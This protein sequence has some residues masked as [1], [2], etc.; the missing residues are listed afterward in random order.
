MFF[1]PSGAMEVGA[2]REVAVEL[3]YYEIAAVPSS[4]LRA[5]LSV[6]RNDNLARVARTRISFGRNE[7]HLHFETARKRR[8]SSVRTELVSPSP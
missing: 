5:G 8:A 7:S 1:C 4:G 3:K 2:V 6:A